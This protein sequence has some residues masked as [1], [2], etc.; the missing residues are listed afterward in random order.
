M[1]KSRVVCFVL[2]L[3]VVAMVYAFVQY[4]LAH[5]NETPRAIPAVSTTAVATQSLQPRIPAVGFFLANQGVVVKAETAGRVSAVHFRSGQTVEQGDVLIT[6][7]N[8]QQ[9]GALKYAKAQH[10]LSVLTYQRYVNLQKVGAVSAEAL[11][12]AKS[13]M[14]SNEGNEIKAQGDY[15]LTEIKAPF[16]GRVGINKISL[17]DYLQTGD[18]VVS[19]QNLNPLYIDFSIPERYVSQLN[20]GEKVEIVAT[21]H[22][23][24]TF[25]GKVDSYETL[26]NQDTG[27]MTVRALVPNELGLLLPGGYAEVTLY[28]GEPKTV[29]AIPQT[30]IVY[31]VAS[32]Y[33]YLVKDNKA[34]VQ[35]VKLG[36]QIGEWIEVTEGLSVGDVIVSAGTNKVHEGSVVRGMSS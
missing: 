20:I 8:T 36:A 22:P 5:P 6:L 13:T 3:V 31:D 28:A 19:L 35:T 12:E 29:M 1:Q 21:T 34:V 33:V 14:D 4:R 17:G 15:D 9:A 11:D 26:I 16:S 27:M 18:E 24:Q 7:N 23:H 10:N 30:A 2:V 32:N 25:E